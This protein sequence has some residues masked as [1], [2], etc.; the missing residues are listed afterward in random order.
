MSTPQFTDREIHVLTR[1]HLIGWRERVERLLQNQTP[2]EEIELFI[3][4][5]N[6]R[7]EE[8]DQHYK[9][10]Q[11]DAH[12]QD[13]VTAQWFI[14]GYKRQCRRNIRLLEDMLD[15]YERMITGVHWWEIKKEYV[16]KW[17]TEGNCYFEGVDYRDVELNGIQYTSYEGYQKTR[18]AGFISFIGRKVQPI[19]PQWELPSK[20][21]LK[22]M[23]LSFD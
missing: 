2:I 15:I 9:E 3:E 6:D 10:P 23:V 17:I 5:W 12:R 20:D 1:G 11:T 13:F 8:I 4:A 14:N 16:R 21:E 7:Y 18:I 22:K 19:D